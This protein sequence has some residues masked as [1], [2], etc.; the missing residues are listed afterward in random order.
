MHSREQSGAS[1]LQR[2]RSVW[3]KRRGDEAA[4]TRRPPD[5]VFVM[6]QAIAVS[7]KERRDLPPWEPT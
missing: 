4:P 6:L 1:K 7:S 2:H 5:G 3:L